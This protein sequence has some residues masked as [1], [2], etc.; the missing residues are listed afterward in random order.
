MKKETIYNINESDLSA[1][2]ALI[3]VKIVCASMMKQEIEMDAIKNDVIDLIEKR[4]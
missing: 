2:I 4:K 1:V 3:M